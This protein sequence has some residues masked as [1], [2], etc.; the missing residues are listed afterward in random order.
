MKRAKITVV[1]AGNIG[2]SCAFWATAKE[3]GDVVLL[4]IDRFKQINDSNGHGAGDAVLRDIGSILRLHVRKS[5]LAARLG[6]DEFGVILYHTG[7]EQAER[8]VEKL[9]DGVRT[10]VFKYEDSTMNAGV[11]I[12]IAQRDVSMKTTQALYNAADK[13]LYQ[14]KLGGRNRHCVYSDSASQRVKAS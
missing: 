8:L 5:D 13:A 6:G 4:D 3:L 7:S 1:G 11:S 9:M 10:H 14:A 2:A 12:G